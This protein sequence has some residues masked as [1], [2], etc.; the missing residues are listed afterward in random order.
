MKL[1]LQTITI[2]GLGAQL[3]QDSIGYYKGFCLI[4][5]PAVKEAHFT[6]L[7]IQDVLS[8]IFKQF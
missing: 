8:K 7:R 3:Y 4:S 1:V 5:Y 6:K 2:N